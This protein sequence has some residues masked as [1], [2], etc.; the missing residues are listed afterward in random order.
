MRWRSETGYCRTARGRGRRIG[1]SLLVTSKQSQ[2]HHARRRMVSL[3]VT[4]SCAG[5]NYSP[6]SI[7]KVQRYAVLHN[8]RWRLHIVAPRL[9]LL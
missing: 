8:E 1:C 4:T 5:Y 6:L 2:H 7:L 9:T 3:L